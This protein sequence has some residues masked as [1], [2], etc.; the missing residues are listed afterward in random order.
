MLKPLLAAILLV[1]APCAA[2]AQSNTSPGSTSAAPPAPTGNLNNPQA[3]SNMAGQPS[4]AHTVPNDGDAKSIPTPVID[5]SPA[6]KIPEPE[7]PPTMK[8]R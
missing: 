3:Q 7:K 1:A 2:F 4:I 6:S 8:I 5:G